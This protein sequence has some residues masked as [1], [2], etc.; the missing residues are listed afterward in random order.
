MKTWGWC[1]SV[2]SDCCFLC[3]PEVSLNGDITVSPFW[4]LFSTIT[5][6][7]SQTHS[8]LEAHLTANTGRP[9]A[10]RAQCEQM[11]DFLLL[12][13]CFLTATTKHLVYFSLD[14]RGEV[15]ELTFGQP[16]VHRLFYGSF[17]KVRWYTVLQVFEPL[18]DACMYEW[19]RNHKAHNIKLDKTWAPR[20]KLIYNNKNK[21]IS[22]YI[23][24][25]NAEKALA[26]TDR[27]KAGHSFTC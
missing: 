19:M 26:V 14:Y 9:Q 5:Q 25:Q 11:G 12:L 24:S 8:S 10:A 7:I 17:H 13:L 22:N 23:I 6:T 20:L 3:C 27:M 2:I 16:Q 15:Q 18:K 21:I 4:P 1:N